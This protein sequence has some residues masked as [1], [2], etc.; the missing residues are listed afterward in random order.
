MQRHGPNC[1]RGRLRWLVYL[2]SALIRIV[3]VTGAVF[4]VRRVGLHSDVL[5]SLLRRKAVALSIRG[6]KERMEIL[7]AFP[8]RT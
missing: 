1:R 4:A 3:G 5:V 6:R 2:V 8:D 7:A